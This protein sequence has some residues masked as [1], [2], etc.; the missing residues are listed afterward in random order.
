[1][2]PVRE[3]EEGGGGGRDDRSKALQMSPKWRRE[4]TRERR[5]EERCEVLTR[6]PR[7]VNAASRSLGSSASDEFSWD[8]APRSS[9]SFFAEPQPP[10]SLTLPPVSDITRK[11]QLHAHIQ[12]VCGRR[13]G[14]P[15]ASRSARRGEVTAAGSYL[16]GC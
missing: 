5:K 3:E 14:L 4:R 6:P 2:E 12:L 16:R 11:E 10:H 9:L 7:R 13:S 15:V 8:S 1:M